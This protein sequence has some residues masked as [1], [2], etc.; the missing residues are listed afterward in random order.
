MHLIHVPC[1]NDMLDFICTGFARF[2]GTDMERKIKNEN[3]CLHRDSNP[4]PTAFEV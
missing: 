2:C 3:I 1:L 4:C